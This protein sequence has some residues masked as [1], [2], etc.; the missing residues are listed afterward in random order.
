MSAKY[1]SNKPDGYSKTRNNIYLERER[2]QQMRT[3][4]QQ[5]QLRNLPEQN[6]ENYGLPS[7]NWVS[8]IFKIPFI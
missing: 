1:V 4:D 8:N 6:R 7:E 3:F 2:R 5:S